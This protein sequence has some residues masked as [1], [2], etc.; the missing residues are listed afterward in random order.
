MCAVCG[1]N[2]CNPRCPNAPE[3]EAV[4]RCSRCGEEIM[5]G[6]KYMAL[7]DG[8]ICE[9]CLED[10]SVEDWLELIGEDLIVAEREEI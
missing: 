10:F 1:Q 6:Y 7:C 9:E 5:P 2:P 4:T 3:P 8:D